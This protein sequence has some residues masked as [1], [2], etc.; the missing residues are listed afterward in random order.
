MHPVATTQANIDVEAS[1]RY[2]APDRDPKG[3]C[4][5]VRSEPVAEGEPVELRKRP[6]VAFVASCCVPLDAEGLKAAARLCEAEAEAEAACDALY[7]QRV[8]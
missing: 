3:A 5:G 1:V 6:L 8:V 2:E 4:E 7:E